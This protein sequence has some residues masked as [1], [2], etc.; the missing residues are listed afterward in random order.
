MMGWNRV[1]F[2]DKVFFT[3]H[4]SL[5]VHSGMSLT[6]SLESLRDQAKSNIFRQVLDDVLEDVKNGQALHKAMAKHEEVFDEFYLGLIEVSEMSGNLEKNLEFL[7]EQ[8]TKTHALKKKIKSAAMYPTF[9]LGLTGA[10]V[11]FIGLF[12]LPK[13][14]D[15][16]DSFEAELPVTTQILLWCAQVAKSYGV[17]IVVGFFAGMMGFGALIRIPPIQYVWH[18]VVLRIP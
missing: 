2:T 1:S 5:M 18:K 13:L 6:E 7:A 8:M 11:I 9:V 17:L 10:I 3:K 15:F 12:I 16:F 14:T 4:L